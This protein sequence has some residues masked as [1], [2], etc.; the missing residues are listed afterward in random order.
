M[1]EYD[2]DMR[3]RAQHG[4]CQSSSASGNDEDDADDDDSS[5]DRRA[6][7]NENQKRQVNPP[8]VQMR[9]GLRPSEQGGRGGCCALGCMLV[10]ANGC[11]QRVLSRGECVVHLVQM[12]MVPKRCVSK[13]GIFWFKLPWLALLGSYRK[14]RTS[15][16]RGSL[17]IP[18]LDG[19][20]TWSAIHPPPLLAQV[21]TP[22]SLPEPPPSLPKKSRGR[23]AQPFKPSPFPPTLCCPFQLIVPRRTHRPL[24]KERRRR[25][26]MIEYY[27]ISWNS[28]DLWC[29]AR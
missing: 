25:G 23:P 16:R 6:P 21:A 4:K 22:H 15:P 17:V 14:E 8:S 13:G 19:T 7:A 24:S 29:V 26:T 1:V 18:R 12:L 10:V 3:A 9:K 11:P 2:R 27:H 28:G 5:S 20:R